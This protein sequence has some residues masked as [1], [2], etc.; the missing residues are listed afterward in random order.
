MTD[1]GALRDL[2]AFDPLSTAERVTG[3]SYKADEGTMALG[4]SLA[5]DHNQRK[6]KALAASGDTHFSQTLAEAEKVYAA[7]G[8]AKVA[9]WPF[10]GSDGVAEELAAWWHPDGLLLT[11]ESYMGTRVNTASLRY[12]VRLH[13]P[14]HPEAW[15][16]LSS[17]GPIDGST[18]RAGS[19]DV[20]EGLI[21]AIEGL[22]EVGAFLPVW[23]RQPF[24]WLLT[25]MDTKVEG[26][27]YA[28]I[29]TR[30]IADLP[31]DVR[32]AIAGEVSA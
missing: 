7:A 13:E 16:R 15:S 29:S 12:N 1:T 11:V 21:V 5:I 6:A 20:R 19:H 31:A 18:A 10:E 2:L 26:Y 23:V 22:R 8:F 28:A 17:H 30:R 32:A 3:E 27:D 24:M 25:Y 14:H 4:F 9:S